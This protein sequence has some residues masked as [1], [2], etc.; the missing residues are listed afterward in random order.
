MANTPAVEVA[1]QKRLNEA[2]EKG[3]PRKRW[4][5][6]LN[7]RQLGTGPRGLWRGRERLGRRRGVFSVRLGVALQKGWTE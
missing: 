7:D 1:E 5:P 6:Y 2:R 4:G 3:I